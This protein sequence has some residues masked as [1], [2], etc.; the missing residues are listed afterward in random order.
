MI[1]YG[2][3]G[4]SKDKY[5]RIGDSTAIESMYRFCRAVVNIFGPHYLREPNEEDSSPIMAQNEARGFRRMLE[6]SLHALV[7]KELPICLARY[8]ERSQRI[9][10]CGARSRGQL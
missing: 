3:S 2:T 8:L 6:A 9:L 10:Q 5:L 4:D 1:T 7:L